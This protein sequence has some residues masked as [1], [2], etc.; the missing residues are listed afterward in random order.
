M[1]CNKDNLK[2]SAEMDRKILN[3]KGENLSF[4][5]YRSFKEVSEAIHRWI[6]HGRN[7][8]CV[9]SDNS[10]L[11]PDEFIQLCERQET[12]YQSMKVYSS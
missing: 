10:Y 8:L 5:K 7:E 11:S 2:D 6:E 9:H 1:F 4:N 3:L 12:N